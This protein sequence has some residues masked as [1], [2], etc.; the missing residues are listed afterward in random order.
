M[1]LSF[2]WLCFNMWLSNSPNF[3][4]LRD[5]FFCVYFWNFYHISEEYAFT[6]LDL[7]PLFCS[8]ELLYLLLCQHGTLL[9][10]LLYGSSCKLRS[11]GLSQALFL[12]FR[13][14]KPF[15][16]L[17][18]FWW[19]FKD[20]LLFLWNG[21]LEFWWDCYC[22]CRRAILTV[23]I[24]PISEEIFPSSGLFSNF[25]Q[26]LTFFTLEVL[27]FFYIFSKIFLR[28]LR[29]GFPWFILGYVYP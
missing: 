7:G 11:L 28:K 4:C 12:L 29:M 5:F 21:A 19:N 17:F 8:T 18:C 10:S 27:H 20:L 15:Q 2:C 25:F 6:G 22:L 9:F 1:W 14:T 13:I 26:G 3:I 24:L 23:F 16:S